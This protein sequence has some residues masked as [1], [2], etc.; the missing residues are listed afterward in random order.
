[1]IF[2]RGQTFF[3]RSV[4]SAA[5][6]AVLLLPGG[7]AFDCYV[8][9]KRN[10]ERPP[11]RVATVYQSSSPLLSS[12]MAY[13]CDARLLTLCIQ[14]PR[15]DS[16]RRGRRFKSCRIDFFNARNPAKVAESSGFLYV[17]F[18]AFFCRSRIWSRIYA[19]FR[20][21]NR[22]APLHIRI[23]FCYPLKSANSFYWF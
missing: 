21:S 13:L 15:F 12:R 16:G 10:F 22:A 17:N 14:N 4:I 9:Q 23:S 2:F 1:M 8:L 11:E 19:F 20:V 6:N 3:Q 18:R 5:E 7:V